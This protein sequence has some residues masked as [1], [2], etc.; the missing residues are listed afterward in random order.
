MRLQTIKICEN[1]ERNFYGWI[2]SS[3]RHLPNFPHLQ[4]DNVRQGFVEDEQYARLAAAATEIWFRALLEVAHT[5]GWRRQELL[6][7]R[8]RQVDLVES[9]I[10]L[11]VGSTKNREGRTVTM[12]SRALLLLRECVRGKTPDD[13]VF[14][15]EDGKP[16]RD[17]RSTWAAAC[18]AAGVGRMMC[19]TCKTPVTDEKC[20]ACG[21]TG[22]RL[23]YVGLILHDM[24][25]TGAR[26]LRRAGVA[27]GVIMRLGGWKTASVFRRYDIVNQA[28]FVDALQKL[29][30]RRADWIELEAA[31][32]GATEEPHLRLRYQYGTNWPCRGRDRQ[33]QKGEL[34][35]L[36]VET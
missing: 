33:K 10:R 21:A 30:Q 4:E 19:K 23:R 24:R 2:S 13:H 15:R 31:D 8:V 27:E 35:A 12:T 34:S 5:Y 11:D 32:R 22:K 6:N 25:R 9:T 14:T 28:D 17:F 18:V 16:V 3:R 7:L 1:C 26:N 36:N 29:E 20:E